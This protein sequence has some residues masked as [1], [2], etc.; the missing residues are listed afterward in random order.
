MFKSLTIILVVSLFA[1]PLAAETTS[2]TLEKDPS[3]KIE[4]K[5]KEGDT[6][7][8]I[9]LRFDVAVGDMRSWNKLESNKISTGDSLVMKR[10]LAPKISVLEPKKV[11][12]RR[13]RSRSYK[14]RRGDTFES[15]ARRNKTTIKK[16]RRMNPRVNPRRLQIGQRKDIF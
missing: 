3:A 13:R 8:S 1:L 7:G 16:V 4:Y 9:A 10:V 15:I 2:S 14:V 12:K 5:V 6:L 11:K